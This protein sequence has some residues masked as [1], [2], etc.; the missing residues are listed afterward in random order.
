MPDYSNN[1]RGEL[2]DPTPEDFVRERDKFLSHLITHDPG[3]MRFIM[4]LAGH[5][6][7]DPTRPNAT[8]IHQCQF[9]GGTTPM[10]AAAVIGLIDDL[11]KKDRAFIPFFIMGLIGKM[12]ESGLA[13]FDATGGEDTAKQ[14]E[15]L[16]AKF[17]IPPGSI[18]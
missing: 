13:K 1:E 16:M 10:I 17:G 14:V 5:E 2:H 15:D 18:N 7:H 3:A 11:M 6:E 8:T 4:L 12:K 9:I